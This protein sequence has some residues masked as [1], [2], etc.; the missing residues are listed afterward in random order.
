M[1]SGGSAQGGLPWRRAGGWVVAPAAQLA[2]RGVTGVRGRGCAA[3]HG[4]GGGWVV[5]SR[6][7]GA[8]RSSTGRR[9]CMCIWVHLE[10]SDGR[11]F[12]RA[13][14]TRSTAGRLFQDDHLL[15]DAGSGTTRRDGGGPALRS[16]RRRRGSSAWPGWPH[17]ADGGRRAAGRAHGRPCSSGRMTATELMSAEREPGQG[18]ER[19]A[20]LPVGGGGTG[21]VRQAG[22]GRARS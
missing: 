15:R 20:A 13:R 6:I 14:R 10:G 22:A 17:G 8:C 7:G 9:E 11:V 18:P 19:E 12:T 2:G 4:A 1:L 16:G 3:K 5:A 21:A